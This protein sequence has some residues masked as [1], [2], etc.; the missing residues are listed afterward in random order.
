[1]N[2]LHHLLLV[3]HIL[4]NSKSA[5]VPKQ[6][7]NCLRYNRCLCHTFI[8]DFGLAQPEES[9]P[10]IEPEDYANFAAWISRY[11]KPSEGCQNCR[12]KKME[13]FF[14]YE[15]QKSC[16]P[17]NALFRE[18]SFCATE[19]RPR[20]VMDTLHAVQEDETMEQGAFTG[21]VALKSFDRSALEP[22]DED[23]D[24]TSRK[25]GTRFPRAAVKILKDWMDQHRDNPYPTEEEKEEL[26][27]ITGL[28]GSQVANWLANTRRRTKTRS[29]GMS[30]SIRSPTWPTPSSSSSSSSSAIDIPF[31]KKD[32]RHNGKT[33]DIMNPLERMFTAN[34]PLL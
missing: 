8:T 14:T 21:I 29:R 33:W 23:N 31:D 19:A 17:C 3:P 4:A 6:G 30:P 24:R 5:Y 13:C 15:G 34:S 20:A 18:C 12:S 7:F 32:I 10:N 22:Q 11:S 1:M 28:K 9:A 16:S 2:H 25:T 26:K 27:A